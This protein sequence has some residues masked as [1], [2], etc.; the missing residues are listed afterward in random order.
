ME[1]NEYLSSL[2]FVNTGKIYRNM[3][4]PKLIEQSLIR[5]EGTLTS[6]G[7]LLVNTGKY[8]GR[9]PKDRFIVDDENVHKDVNWGKVNIPISEEKFEEVYARV[10]AY[11]ENRDLFVFDGFAGADRRY[12][13]P[14]RFINQYAA[15]NL[16]VHQLF[17][18]PTA[19]ELSNFKPEFTVICAPGFLANPVIDN[20]NT[21]AFI[22]LNITKKIIIIGG[23]AY[24]GEI[25]KSVFSVMNF[26]LP[27]RGI[28]PMHCSSN[29]GKNGDTA[30]FF[31]LSGTGKTTLSAD[32]E[33]NLIG[34][35]EHGWSDDGVF[36]FEGGCYAKCIRLSYD[37][38][39]EIFN[40]IKFG[41]LIENVVADG[42]G[43][44]DYNDA[45][46]T[47]NT[48]A[49]YPINYIPGSVPCGSGDHPKTIIFLTA[50]AFGVLPPISKLTKE[51]AMYHF[52][53]GYTSKVAGTER[54]IIEPQATFSSCFGEPFMILN[55]SRYANMLGEKIS[56]YN[57]RV[58]LVNTGWTGGKYGVGKRMK[59]SYTRAM[60]TA[61]IN[62]E[63]DDVEYAEHPVFKVLMPKSVNNVPS[64]VLDPV[65]TW[66]DKEEYYKCANELAVRFS[67]NFEKF[68]DVPEDIKS[69][70]PV[71][72]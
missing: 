36:N 33:R 57:T 48:R 46:Y 53:S 37:S 15:Q 26:L 27:K 1:C 28:L 34:D 47:E 4:V 63:L 72:K 69:A 39:P 43:D 71:V 9:S 35:D 70:A 45:K 12:S 55:P 7:A 38:E 25:K 18:R 24:S 2:G 65:N 50:D 6:N 20:T 52:I 3:A 21:E 56:K 59:L 29:I 58:F 19:E 67:K 22:I 16:F 13:L 10:L 32:P 14:V 17:I 68:K 60:V 5:G 8:T 40:A 41:T 49:A 11:L 44:I 31:G 61:A 64:Y 23:S 51:Q 42:N 66:S 54:G 30:L 62:G